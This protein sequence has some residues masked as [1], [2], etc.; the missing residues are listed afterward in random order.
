MS[1]LTLRGHYN[2]NH[3]GG[4]VPQ[5]P[6][7]VFHP[8]GLEA[9]RTAHF[10]TEFQV[11]GRVGWCDPQVMQIAADILGSVAEVVRGLLCLDCFQ[12]EVA[13]AVA[14]PS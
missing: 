13:G 14:F 2:G 11:S 5:P 10:N 4:I 12:H 6:A 1:A 9:G 3:P 8:S 7:N